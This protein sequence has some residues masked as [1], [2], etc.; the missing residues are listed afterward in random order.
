MA[1]PPACELLAVRVG[2]RYAEP[3]VAPDVHVR[4][5]C[6]RVDDAPLTTANSDHRTVVLI[7]P[8]LRTGGEPPSR[9]IA[10]RRDR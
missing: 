4:R 2:C 3:S 8:T 5:D 6:Q 7:E 1:S 10:P 9:S